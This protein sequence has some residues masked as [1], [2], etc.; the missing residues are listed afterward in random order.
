MAK[1]Y[2]IRER[3]L[4][5]PKS[6]KPFK[7]SRTK[8]ELFMECPRCFYMDRRLGVGRPSTPGFT[9]N[10]AVDH[11]LKKEF[12]LLRENGEAHELMK[13]YK[14]DAVPYKHPDMDKWRE[15]FEGIEHL[16]K[17]TNLILSGAIDDIWVNKKGELHIVDYKA[18]S[19]EKEISLED[20]F[21]QGYKTQMEIYQWLF[22][23]EGFKVNKTGYFVFANA[24]KNRPHFDGKLE[25][26]LTILPHE[27]DD[28]WIEQTVVDI[29]KCLMSA[30]IPESSPTCEHSAYRKAFALT[31][32]KHKNNH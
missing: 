27:G 10:I 14:I 16:H 25:F 17:K 24:R 3:N 4:F 19:T 2:K 7:L 12:D 5:D 31:T 26:E 15:N 30:S 8:I 1:E 9:L 11:L 29:H 20:E 18:T 32:R 13:K 22:R 23:Q 6:K 28:S 21:K